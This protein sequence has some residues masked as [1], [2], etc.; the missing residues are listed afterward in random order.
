LNAA[1]LVKCLLYNCLEPTLTYG[2][3]LD[4]FVSVKSEIPQTV[5]IRPPSETSL[6]REYVSI[7]RFKHMY[8]EISC[9]SLTS[10]SRP[11]LLSSGLT[12]GTLL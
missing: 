11:V 7:V 8:I 3:G 2:T 6:N 1:F 10:N 5:Q 4:L 12:S 9:C